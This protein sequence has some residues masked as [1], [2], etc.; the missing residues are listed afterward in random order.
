[1]TQLSTLLQRFA[2]DECGATVVEYVAIASGLGVTLLATLGGSEG[3][4]SQGIE[5]LTSEIKKASPQVAPQ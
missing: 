3:V 1:M 4:L 2:E 5:L